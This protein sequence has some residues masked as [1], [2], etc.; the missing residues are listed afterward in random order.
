MFKTQKTANYEKSSAEMALND[1]L[2]TESHP[3]LSPASG[4]FAN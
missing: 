1:E 2:L 3:Y 4:R